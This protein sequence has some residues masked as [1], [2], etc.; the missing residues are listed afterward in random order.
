MQGRNFHIEY[1]SKAQLSLPKFSDEKLIKWLVYI[2]DSL[3][4]F[5][6]D[7]IIGCDLLKELSIILK[8]GA[9]MMIWHNAA[10]PMKELDAS[11][12]ELYY[13]QDNPVNPE[14]YCVWHMLGTNFELA[15]FWKYVDACM[16]LNSTKE[17]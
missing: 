7:M 13:I 6:Y 17:N 10:V 15:E 9:E 11:M 2:N 1:H 4:D 8:F 14:C 5:N 12:E 16:H 3:T